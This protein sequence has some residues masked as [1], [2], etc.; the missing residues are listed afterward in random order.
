MLGST[1]R[2]NVDRIPSLSDT[3]YPYLDDGLKSIKYLEVEKFFPGVDTNK[4]HL[5]CQCSVNEKNLV[6]QF[7]YS[8]TQFHRYNLPNMNQLYKFNSI[9]STQKPH[10]NLDEDDEP[11]DLSMK[12]VSCGSSQQENMYGTQSYEKANKCSHIYCNCSNHVTSRNYS[13]GDNSLWATNL[14]KMPVL[15]T[16]EVYSTL[17][18]ESANTTNNSYYKTDE[19]LFCSVMKNPSRN[20]QF[21]HHQ[22]EINSNNFTYDNTCNLNKEIRRPYTEAELSAAVK[23]ICFGRLGTRRAASVYG[24]PRSTLRNKICKLNELKKLEEKR[25]GGKSIVLSEFL[26]NLFQ[27]TK[28][29][30]E[31][32]SSK[33]DCLNSSLLNNDSTNLVGKNSNLDGQLTKLQYTKEMKPRS[34]KN[35][36]GYLMHTASRVAS[37]FQVN[38]R[39]SYVHKKTLDNKSKNGIDKQMYSRKLSSNPK[40][41]YAT[42]Q[43]QIPQ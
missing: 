23:A 3:C 39:R 25:L 34:Q 2:L 13:N 19:S 11:L 31:Y 15:L 27:Q 1:D 5:Q 33:R 9:Q 10:A 18:D 14:L 7:I 30:Y 42:H 40:L 29:C 12:T 16:Q 17:S 4:C 24:I 38:C 8:F 20:K 32:S 6:E 22:Y 41:R 35:S 36:T 26:L 28:S 21:N 43:Q 37:I